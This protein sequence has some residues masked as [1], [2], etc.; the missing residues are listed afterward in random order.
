M[1][2]KDYWLNFCE[3]TGSCCCELQTDTT[4]SADQQRDS[5]HVT[6]R[7]LMKILTFLTVSAQWTKCFRNTELH[8]KCIC[9]KGV[10]FEELI[11]DCSDG[12]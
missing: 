5:G 2:L 6:L 3:N 7:L 4:Q 10:H 9:E 1:V 8:A 11:S 12:H